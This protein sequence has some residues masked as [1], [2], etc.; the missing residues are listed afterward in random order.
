MWYDV[1]VASDGAVTTEWLMVLE[2]E[3]AGDK[4]VQ[5]HGKSSGHPCGHPES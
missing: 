4:E 2:S 1:L 3:R 5:P